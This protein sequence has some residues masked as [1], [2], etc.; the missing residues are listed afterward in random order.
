MIAIIPARSGSK[1]IPNKNV[2][3]LN[4]KPLLAYSIE[5]ALECELID[6][7]VVSSD[8]AYYGLTAREYGAEFIQRPDSI[9]GDLSTDY[10]LIEHLID[11]VESPYIVFLRP[12]TPL[13]DAKVVD[14]A[15][16][17]LRNGYY[18]S[19]LR[20]V[21]ESPESAHKELCMDDYLSTIDGFYEIDDANRPRQS[22]RKTYHPNGYV[23]IFRTSFVIDQ[24]LLYGDKSVGYITPYAT[25]VDTMDQWNFLE[26]EL[27]NA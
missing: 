9:S 27:Q 16:R 5:T 3:R 6:R 19:S 15:I 23:D 2:K 4:G 26:W 20:S 7:V 8:S 21:H 18:G 11:E 14:E 13:R 25:E 17:R 24:K 22:Y 12:T 10:E 1:G